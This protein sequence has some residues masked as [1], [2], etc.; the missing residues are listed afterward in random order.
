MDQEKLF[1][2]I[3]DQL[4][5]SASDIKPESSFADDLGADSLDQV[6]MVMAVEEKWGIVID[7]NDAEKFEK[8]QNVIDYLLAL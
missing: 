1:G 2:I 7:D 3:A 5:I 4:D 8:V 6:E